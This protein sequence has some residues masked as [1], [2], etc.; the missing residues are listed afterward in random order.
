MV[1]IAQQLA[2]NAEHHRAVTYYQGGERRL[3]GRVA[4]RGEPVQQ[5]PI[6]HAGDRAAVKE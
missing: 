2:A 1:P 3:A 4:P 5:L 6:G